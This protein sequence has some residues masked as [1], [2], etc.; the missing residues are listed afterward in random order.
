MK[1]QVKTID[2]S[3]YYTELTNI[4]CYEESDQIRYIV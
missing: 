4:V 1:R 2:N 3:N